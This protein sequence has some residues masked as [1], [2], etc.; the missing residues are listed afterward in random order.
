MIRN[1]KTILINGLN[2]KVLIVYLRTENQIEMTQKIQGKSGRFSRFIEHV[3]AQILSRLGDSDYNLEALSQELSISKVQLYRKVK[4]AT[5]RSTALY[6]RYVRLCQAKQLLLQTD[7]PIYHVAL[8]V[9][10]ED[11]SYF[12]KSFALEFGLSPSALRQ[13]NR[14]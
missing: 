7:W 14:S 11:H 4:Q 10:F 12:S 3:N 5:G 6:I 2:L 8:K 13:K 9:G 1:V